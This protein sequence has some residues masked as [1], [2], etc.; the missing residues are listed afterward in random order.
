M[1]PGCEDCAENRGAVCSS[2]KKHSSS[3]S[4]CSN[5]SL[6][7]N[8]HHMWG[9][10]GGG[11]HLWQQ[12]AVMGHYEDSSLYL[13]AHKQDYTTTRLEEQMDDLQWDEQGC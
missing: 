8:S 3:S 7:G 6:Y 9:G 10:G 11:E 2:V 4:K 13:S 5:T 1:K 12:T